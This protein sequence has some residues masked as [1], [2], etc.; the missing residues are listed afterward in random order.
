MSKKRVSVPIEPVVA[1]VVCVVAYESTEISTIF[2][3]THILPRFVSDN[4]RKTFP[5]THFPSKN[6]TIALVCPDFDGDI[7]EL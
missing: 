7:W 6:S 5:H 3:F 1:T 2:L 4:Y